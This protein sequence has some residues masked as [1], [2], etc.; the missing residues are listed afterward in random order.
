MPRARY[1][2][3]TEGSG[4]VGPCKDVELLIGEASSRSEGFWRSSTRFK[5]KDNVES[6]SAR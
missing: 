3:C 6:Q 1:H 5:K 4:T 2:S